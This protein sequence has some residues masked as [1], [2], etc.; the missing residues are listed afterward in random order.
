MK[1]N[2]LY[3]AMGAALL[4]GF[5][6]LNVHGMTLEESVAQ[7]IDQNPR[8]SGQ[9]ARYVSVLKDKRAAFADYLP[10]VQLYAGIG[11]SDIDYKQN[12]KIESETNPQ[13]LGVRLSQMLFDGFRTPAEVS[14]LGYEAEAARL[15]LISEAEN[16]ALEVAQS[17]LNVLKAAAQVELSERNVIDHQSIFE[18]IQTRHQKGLSSDSDLAQVASRVATS[19]S[20]LAAA[21]NNLYDMQ[22]V[23]FHLVGTN[24]EALTIPKADANI[25]PDNLELA[26]QK[27]ISAHPE[28]RSAISDT[29]AA[30]EQYN[31]DKSGYWPTLSIDVEAY[32][33]DDMGG[34]EGPDDDARV[35]LNL[36]YDLYSGG[37]TTAQAESALWR[38]EAALAVRMRTERQVVEGTKFAWNASEFLQQ[39]IDFYQQNVEM[40]VKA[41]Q[42]YNEQFKLGRRSLLDVLDA[43]VEV[44]IAR[45][46]YLNSY[47]DHKAAQYRLLNAVGE[48]LTSMRVDT[49]SQWQANAEV[50]Q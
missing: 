25:V 15:Q 40:A 32:D 3:R 1:F 8:V 12:N 23:Y 9:Y 18:D 21:R 49:P 13:Q 24:P 17:Y 37:R 5:F 39:Q 47:Y 41:E 43:K 44:F 16:V 2:I 28:I 35:M 33:N 50:A 22:A 48:L 26:L 45:R 42:G 30:N 6:A 19:R 34:I 20:A 4:C 29:Q 38:K 10:Q 7:A 46:S 36:K 14:R 11:Y 27:A 31:R